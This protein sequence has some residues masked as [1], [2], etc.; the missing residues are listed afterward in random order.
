MKY[1]D[2]SII[3]PVY[4]AE[5]LLER[6][7][8]SLEIQKL[9]GSTYEVIVADGGSTDKS[10]EICKKHKAIVI[11]N[12]QQ[13]AEPGVVLGIKQASSDLVMVL[14]TDNIF[15]KNNAL[16]DIISVFEDKKI[17]AAFPIQAAAQNDSMFSKYINAFTDPYTHFVY[18]DAS[19]ARTFK[20]IYTTIAHTSLY[21]VYDYSSNSSFPLLALA[22][23]FTVRKIFIEKRKNQYDDVLVIYD[24][25]KQGKQIAYV[26]GVTLNHYTADTIGQFIQKQRRAVG[27]AMIRKNSGISLRGTYF[28]KSQQVRRYMYF[29]YSLSIIAPFVV[30]CVQFVKT[31]ESMWL[32][33]PYIVYISAVVILYEVGKTV[34]QRVLKKM[35]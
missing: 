9:R 33:H 34:L 25:I 3:V 21:D 6:F 29:P 32:I 14:A 18:W 15:E 13:L 23:G 28:S 12:S 20:K 35:I 2:L 4:N 11:H 19:N 26:H 22:Q 27:N 17:A 31:R 24:L 5:H 30:G 1:P 8:L 7:F 10:V 16:A